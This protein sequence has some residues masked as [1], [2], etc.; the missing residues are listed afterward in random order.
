MLLQRL[1]ELERLQGTG[2]TES[3]LRAEDT[4]VR[5]GRCSDND[6]ATTAHIHRIARRGNKRQNW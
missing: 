6:T 1:L 3:P 5:T 4:A 2:G